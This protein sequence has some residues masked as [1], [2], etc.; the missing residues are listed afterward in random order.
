M[1]NLTVHYFT[2]KTAALEV[3]LV[4]T[5][6]I[7]ATQKELDCTDSIWSVLWGT[8]LQS[9]VYTGALEMFSL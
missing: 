5:D 4:V 6:L 3:Y 7:M 9:I 2:G 1:L 8:T